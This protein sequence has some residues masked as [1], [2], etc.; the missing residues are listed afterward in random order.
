IRP[1]Q[2]FALSLPF[3]LLER[4]QAQPVIRV[5]RK[6]LLTAMGIR[7]LD[8]ADPA[9]YPRFEGTLPERDA[10]YHQG[11]VWPWL[12]GP[13]VQGYLYACGESART[14]GFCRKL[15]TQFENQLTACCLGSL[16]EVYDAEPPQRPGGCPAQ[17]WSVAQIALALQKVAPNL[18]VPKTE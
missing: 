16:A 14:I 2:L 1:N 18:S 8:P 9:Y 4:K 11:T 5:V 17:L 3:P 6:K 12:M 10:A 15:L 7:T 13:F